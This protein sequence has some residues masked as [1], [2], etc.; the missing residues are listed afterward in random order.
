MELE[1]WIERLTAVCDTARYFHGMNVVEL[2]FGSGPRWDV[3]W[4]MTNEQ[5]TRGLANLELEHLDADGMLFHYVRPMSVPFTAT[6]MK[7]T[8]YVNWYDASGEFLM[9]AV[10]EPGLSR[11]VC[12]TPFSWVLESPHPIPGGPL[13]VRHGA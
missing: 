9:S 10:A 7:F 6:D 11:F 8:I 1:T 12:P 5:R 3:Y 2:A 4:A 13:K